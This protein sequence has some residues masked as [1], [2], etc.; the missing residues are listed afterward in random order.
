MTHDPIQSEQNRAMNEL[1]EYLDR[2]FNGSTKRGERK[3]GFALLVFPF[4]NIEGT[5]RVHYIGNS[6]RSDM[7]VAL[8]ELV[9]RWEGRVPQETPP[10]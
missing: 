8:K 1:A 9:A 4:G 5:G 3:W 10:Q 6:E 7:L 2:T